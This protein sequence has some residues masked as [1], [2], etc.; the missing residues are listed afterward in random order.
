MKRA[1]ITGVTG[2]DGSYLSKFLL[3]KNYKIIGFIRNNSDKDYSNHTFLGIKNK[4]EY[5]VVD[6]L[7]VNNLV[8]NIKKYQPDEIYN[9]G[10]LSSVGE[11]FSN[12]L[13][14]FKSNIMSVVNLLEAIR[15][16]NRN[17]KFYQ[18][19]SSEMFGKAKNLPIT[20]DTPMHP[21]S[22]YGI[23]KAS[24]HWATVNYREA[25][26]LYSCSG[27]LFNHESVLRGNDFFI[28]KVIRNSL[29]I[30]KGEKKHLKLGNLNVKRDF[31]YSPEYVKAMWLML[32]QKEPE[33]FI[34]CSGKS[35]SLKEIVKYIFEKLNLNMDNLIIDKDLFRPAEIKDIYGD[36]SKALE[37]LKW[38][39]KMDF[40]SV[41]D[42]LIEE[43][44]KVLFDE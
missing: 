42:I 29:R 19:S 20:L 36:N 4:I 44:K 16:T 30:A 25:Y 40:F 28:K 27:I 1:I 26:G 39:Y 43:E 5:Q 8:Q 38:D 21:V 35:I 12:P 2:Q 37:K 6:L 41:L 18:A 14:T 10:A 31:G 17:I 11:S 9:L 7:D 13:Y 15:L 24:A 32:Q 33:D 34:I 22:P 23:S 3:K